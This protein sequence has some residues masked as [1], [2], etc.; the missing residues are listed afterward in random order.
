MR[1]QYIFWLWNRSWEISVHTRAKDS[2]ASQFL[3]AATI[4][5]RTMDVAI[6]KVYIDGPCEFFYKNRWSIEKLLAENFCNQEIPGPMHC[7][8]FSC[9]I[10]EPADIKAW[11]IYVYFIYGYDWQYGGGRHEESD[12]YDRSSIGIW[13]QGTI[14]IF[15]KKKMLKEGA[16]R[17]KIDFFLL[18]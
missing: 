7:K 5:K 4:P 12:I 10:P 6:D 13:I 17:K 16:S 14:Q 1:V 2:H 11:S 9:E 8:H 15:T 3:Y 18:R